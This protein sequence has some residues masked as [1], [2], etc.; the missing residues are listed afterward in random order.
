MCT[1]TNCAAPALHH[2]ESSS[3]W[4]VI[5]PGG[6]RTQLSIAE[7]VKALDYEKNDYDL[8]SQRDFASEIEASAYARGLANIHG[9]TI[10]SSSNTDGILD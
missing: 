3:F 5:Y 8:A 2:H 10:K 1:C 6:D 4:I 9:L 7:I